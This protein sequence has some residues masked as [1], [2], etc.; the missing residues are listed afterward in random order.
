MN[1][2][3]R[4]EDEK[5]AAGEDWGVLPFDEQADDERWDKLISETDEL[6]ARA[7]AIESE[8]GEISDEVNLPD[9][10]TDRIEPSPKN[11]E[12]DIAGMNPF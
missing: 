1:D 11:E 8:F 4:T 9:G 5:A 6:A 3:K 2:T 10:S 12:D 7:A